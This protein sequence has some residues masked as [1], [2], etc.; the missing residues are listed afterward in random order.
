MYSRGQRSD[1]AL[2]NAYAPKK[3]TVL[4]VYIY[5]GGGCACAVDC[6]TIEID[7]DMVYGG[8]KYSTAR[9][10]RHLIHREG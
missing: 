1:V 3:Q 7:I 6:D 10:Q 8:G 5:G 4:Y 2:L 9:S